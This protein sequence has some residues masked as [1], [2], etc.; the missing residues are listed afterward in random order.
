MS[1][2]QCIIFPYRQGM[3]HHSCR[4]L[5]GSSIRSE[6]NNIVGKL[7]CR[8]INHGNPKGPGLRITRIFDRVMG[9]NA[10]LMGVL[11]RLFDGI[12]EI[13]I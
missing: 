9:I 7:T 10:Y 5:N 11:T 6:T 13:E 4:E 12:G 3:R 8:C 2:N 1:Y